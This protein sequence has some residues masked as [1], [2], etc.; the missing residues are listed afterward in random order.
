[1][2]CSVTAAF[3]V[4]DVANAVVGSVKTIDRASKVIVIRTGDGADRAFHYT[5][6]VAVHGGKEIGDDAKDA[7]HGIS[8]GSKVVAHYSSR[9]SIDTVHELDNLGDDGLEVT[10]GTA[11]KI[12]HG[13]KQASI[14][15][16]DG[17]VA[18]FRMTDHAM[19]DTARAIGNDGDHT[20]KVTVYYTEEAG[21]KTAHYIAKAF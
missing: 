21:K 4:E 3:A 17:S 5:A 13:T 12:D 7:L 16:A 1:M 11:V 8:T 2:A 19:S 15:L 20:G 10:E 14:K 9:G 18:T 6:D